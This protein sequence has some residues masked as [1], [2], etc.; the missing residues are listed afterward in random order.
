MG[1]PLG[2]DV[3]DQLVRGV[4]IRQPRPPRAEVHLVD[5][6][7]LRDRL[8]ARHAV[9]S[10]RHPTRC[11]TSPTTTDAVAGGTSAN[12]AIGSAL[13]TQSPWRGQ[14]LELVG[15][16]HPEAGDEQL[17]DAAAAHRAHRVPWPVPA[18]EVADHA[19]GAGVRRPDGEGGALRAVERA[20]VRA[21]HAPE[22]LVASF[23]DQVQVELADRRSEAVRIV[24]DVVRT[25]FVR[26]HAARTCRRSPERCPSQ[27][28]PADVLEG[29]AGAV[30]EDGRDAPRRADGA[31]GWSTPGRPRH[32]FRDAC[33]ARRADRGAIRRR[34]HPA[35]SR[36]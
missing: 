9:P 23:A 5:R 13:S 28:P 19:H 26:G 21:E 22:L 29:H 3:V 12:R 31:R 11:T 32:P 27:I 30:G 20:H 15:R 34:R 1:E 6:H 2:G 18:V 36:S 7:R 17:P 10:R 35:G 25:V 24:R 16:A 14:Q 33:R 8:R 4:A